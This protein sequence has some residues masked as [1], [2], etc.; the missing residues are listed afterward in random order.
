MYLYVSP[1]DSKLLYSDNKVSDFTVDLP[2]SLELNGRW[3][4]ALVEW[5]MNI[6]VKN[7]LYVYCDI[8]QNSV[9]H[10]KLSPMLRIMKNSVISDPYYIPV[11]REYVDRIRFSV[12]TIDDKP[13][14]T[15]LTELYLV[16]HLKKE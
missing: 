8:V 9:I 5:G 3:L 16:L 11:T 12:R 13:L 7:N 15:K 2:K 10:G 4:C 14:P 1:A 6:Q